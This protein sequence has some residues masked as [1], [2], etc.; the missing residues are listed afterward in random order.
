MNR[1]VNAGFNHFYDS[2]LRGEDPDET[3]QDRIDSTELAFYSGVMWVLGYLN[4]LSKLPSNTDGLE[5]MKSDIEL[6]C[7]RARAKADL[8]AEAPFMRPNG[9][10][11]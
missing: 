10:I 9:D 2:V 6:F 11:N 3:E 4:D 5:V 1:P 8:L 7:D